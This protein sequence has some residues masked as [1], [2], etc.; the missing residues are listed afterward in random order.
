MENVFHKQNKRIFWGLNIILLLVLLFDVFVIKPHYDDN[1]FLWKIIMTES[2]SFTKNYHY[3]NDLF[4]IQHIFQWFYAAWPTVAWFT[5]FCLFANF[6][7]IALIANLLL[8]YGIKKGHSLFF[9]LSV[10]AAAV[11]FLN[12]NLLW[13]HHNRVAFLM[14]SSALVAQAVGMEY[15]T[16]FGS[17]L[18]Y[19]L[20]GF[21]WFV[22]GV[23]VRPEA[24]AAS[25]LLASAAFLVL[26]G[27]R[28]KVL[29]SALGKH[30]IL[31]ACLFGY[32]IYQIN[33]SNQYYYKLEPEGEY[34][35]IDRR[36][37]I[38][39]SDMKTAADSGKY[40]AASNFML[41]DIKAVNP[42]FIRSIIK[43]ENNSGFD[44]FLFFLNLSPNRGSFWDMGKASWFMLNLKNIFALFVLLFIFLLFSRK[45]K[46]A[47]FLAVYLLFV[48]ILYSSVLSMSTFQRV[49]DPMSG[50]TAVWLIL[51]CL[52]SAFVKERNLFFSVFRVAFFLYVIGLFFYMFTDSFEKSRQTAASEKE[53]DE[54]V[55]SVLSGSSRKYIVWASYLFAPSDIYNTSLQYGNKQV[56]YMEFAQFSG[57]EYFLR[58]VSKVTGCPGDDFR[59]RLQFL[60]DNRADMVILGTKRKLGIYNDY[61]QKVYGM[62]LGLDT[63]MAQPVHGR[64][65]SLMMPE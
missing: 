21:A 24:A 30:F 29:F 53:M 65:S 12:G 16:G 49:L 45:Y 38:P 56:L 58:T 19:R 13:V 15:Q 20:G 35:V 48:L 52:S 43:R 57:N 63:S 61:A 27:I 54:K 59:C 5:F 60:K 8:L 22:L 26:Y 6:L 9:S 50:V 31:M 1:A 41:G 10:V 11:I 42:E 23:L 33:F 55:Q 28:F 25:L 37:I 40:I 3:F 51:L 39:L 44:K 47:A 36:N 32:Y 34:E 18:W 2:G 64:L 14:V 7:S 46:I 4:L 17:K 62:E